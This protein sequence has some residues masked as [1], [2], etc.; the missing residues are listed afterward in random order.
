MLAHTN[1]RLY[2]L[3]LIEYISVEASQ[4]KQV[5]WCEIICC[6]PIPSGCWISG[7]WW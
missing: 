3:Q 6:N 7:S 5:K 1:M 4:V 2:K